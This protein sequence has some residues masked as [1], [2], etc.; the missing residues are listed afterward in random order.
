MNPCDIQIQSVLYHNEK[1]FLVR[2]L[3]NIEN[4]LTVNRKTSNEVNNCI[5]RYGDASETPIFTEAELANL[6][7]EHDGA[8]EFQ[9]VFFG[10]NT[11][12]AKGHNRL[13]KDCMTDYLMIMNPDVILSP[14]FFTAILHPFDDT[15]NAV[16]LVEARQTPIEHPK[17]YD[18]ETG[19]TSW[20]AT[21]C[22]LTPVS[23]FKAIDGFDEKTFFLYCDDVDYSWRVRL[24]GQ[25]IIYQP[26][27]PV[28][29][30]KRITKD[31]GWIASEAERYY[32]AEASLMMAYKWSNNRQWKRLIKEFNAS[33]DDTLK[34][35]AVTFSERLAAGDLPS[36][37]DATHQVATFS[38]NLYTNHRF[39]I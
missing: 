38:G 11:G 30:P 5:V 17:E 22:A 21:A 25:K 16:G 2:A 31:G 15:N 27:A 26:I 18:I 37:L 9:Y 4:A 10:E 34:K 32:S 39:D 24:F 33:Q 7:E 8:F 6:R 3:T 35:A 19:E 29:H 36:Q 12:S 13:A 1:K 20:A 28:F 23:T 14:H